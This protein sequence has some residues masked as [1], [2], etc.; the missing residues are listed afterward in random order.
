MKFVA[1][2]NLNFVT[3]ELLIVKP[4]TKYNESGNKKSG[5]ESTLE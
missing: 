1:K 5:T 4:Q 2:K 3:L